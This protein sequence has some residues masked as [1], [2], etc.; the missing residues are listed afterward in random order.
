MALAKF[1]SW[2]RFPR[3][4]PLSWL[5]AI[6]PM[7]LGALAAHRVEQAPQHSKKKLS[8]LFFLL[9]QIVA[10]DG[11]VEF[12]FGAIFSKC[13]WVS[14][15]VHV[16]AWVYAA[17]VCVCVSVYVCPGVGCVFWVRV[18]CTASLSDSRFSIVCHTSC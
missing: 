3:S 10:F 14:V 15:H 9:S 12:R 2:P 7:L 17:R 4:D 8:Q 16:D 6:N 13:M 1:L 11:C 18:L 5:E